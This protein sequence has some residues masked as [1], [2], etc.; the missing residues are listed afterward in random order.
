MQKGRGSS[1]LSSFMEV[2]EGTVGKVSVTYV[3]Q[4]GILALLPIYQNVMFLPV[5]LNKASLC[6]QLTLQETLP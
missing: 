4:E 2:E 5:P 1:G 6:P 3:W